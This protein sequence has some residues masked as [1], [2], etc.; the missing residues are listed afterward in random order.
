VRKLFIL[1]LTLALI[2]MGI[3]GCDY[4]GFT[5]IKEITD[6]PLKF[7][8][9]EVKVKGI[10]EEAL[11]I[12]L[13]ET[14]VYTLKDETGTITVIGTGAKPNQGDSVKVKGTVSTAIKIGDE[15]FRTHIKENKR[16]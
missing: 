16:W 10:V 1:Y 9:K 2:L 4:I 5:R 13:T 11:R 8:G 14:V 6:N 15:T 3:F 7:E 12:P